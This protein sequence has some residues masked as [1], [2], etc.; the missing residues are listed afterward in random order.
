MKLAKSTWTLLALTLALGAWA[1]PASAQVCQDGQQT[2]TLYAG[3]TIE[4]G[5]VTVYNTGT[6]LFVK[7]QLNGDWTFDEAH[8]A[9][10]SSLDGIP[11]TKAG[12]PKP[13]KF[14]YSASVDDGVTTVLFS[15]DSSAWQP[16]TTL[17]IAAHAALRS[18]TYGAQTGWGA[19][20]SF[21]GANW[22][23]YLTFTVHCTFPE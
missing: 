6:Q 23:T 22:A 3:Q 7:Y 11:Q 8:L 2:V 14:P 5:T 10:S 17:Y 12:N 21:P 20:A 18:P 19:G 4:A 13:G 16:N 15:V 1:L 9:V